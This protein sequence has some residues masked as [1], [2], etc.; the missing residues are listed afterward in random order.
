MLCYSVAKA[1]SYFNTTSYYVKAICGLLKICVI[2]LNPNVDLSDRRFILSK[3]NAVVPKQPFIMPI[4][5]VI[6]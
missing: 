6:M 2:M 5:R 3:Y 1:L 4:G